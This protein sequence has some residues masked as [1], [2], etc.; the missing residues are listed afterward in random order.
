MNKESFGDYLLRVIVRSS[1]HSG[2]AGAVL[3]LAV[4][5]HLILLMLLL[6]G[7]GDLVPLQFHWLEK[8]IFWR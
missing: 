5:G 8:L 3:I 7:R 2:H 4:I 1:R 6:F